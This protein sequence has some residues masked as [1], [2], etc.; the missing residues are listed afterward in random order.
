MEIRYASGDFNLV[1]DPTMTKDQTA[2]LQ[3][4]LS[5]MGG[6]GKAIL[7]PWRMAFRQLIITPGLDLE[8]SGIGPQYDSGRGTLLK[9]LPGSNCDAIVTQDLTGSWMHW[10]RLS[11]FR[12]EGTPTDTVGSGI[13]FLRPLGEGTTI[14]RVFVKGFPE[15]GIWLADGAVPGKLRDLHLFQNGQ[16]GLKLGSH[17]ALK[18]F[19]ATY[20]ETVSGDDNGLGLIHLVKLQKA[21]T[22]IQFMHVKSE[23]DTTKQNDMIHI[24]DCLC[25]VSIHTASST[26]IIPRTV[27]KS[28]VK[29][30][31][32]QTPRVSIHD[33]G[34]SGIDYLINDTANNIT[35]PAGNPIALYYKDGLLSSWG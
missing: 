33:P 32:P 29:I 10:T 19:Y 13:K 8:G 4:F 28:M 24:E 23:G 27:I 14:D 18:R 35:V 5:A 30:T 9:Q 7:P 20:I 26:G 31:G 15:N 25:N 2:G 22:T 12:L 1:D 11:N 3:A 6:S 17:D 34:W 21:Y 16:Y